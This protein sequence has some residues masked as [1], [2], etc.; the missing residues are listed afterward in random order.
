[1]IARGIVVLFLLLTMGMDGHSQVTVTDDVLELKTG[2]IDI[3]FRKHTTGIVYLNRLSRVGQNGLIQ[4]PDPDLAKWKVSPLWLVE[5][6]GQPDFLGPAQCTFSDWEIRSSATRHRIQIVWDLPVEADMLQ[7][8]ANIDIPRGGEST[9]WTLEIRSRGGSPF[10]VTR[11]RY[12]IVGDMVLSGPTGNIRIAYPNSWG[13]EYFKAENSAVFA[14][15]PSSDCQM[16]FMAYYN[17]RTEE[18]LYFCAL[19]T[20]GY[21]KILSNHEGNPTIPFARAQ[22]AVLPEATASTRWETPYATEVRCYSGNW[23]EAA[24]FYRQWRLSTAGGLRPNSEKAP[25]WLVKNDFWFETGPENDT[26]FDFTN[27]P[28]LNLIQELVDSLGVSTAIH[29]YNWYKYPFDTYYPDY[30]PIRPGFDSFQERMR[31]SGIRLVPYINGRIADKRIIEDDPRFFEAVCRTNVG[32]SPAIASREYAGNE[33]GT[34]C[35]STAFWQDTLVSISRRLIEEFGFDGVYFDQICN[36]TGD[37]CI[38]PGHGHLSDPPTPHPFS[39]GNHWVSGYEAMLKKVHQLREANPDIMFF[40]EDAADAWNDLFSGYLMVNCQ[41][42]DP[43]GTYRLVPLFPAVYSGYAIPIGFQYAQMPPDKWLPTLLSKFGRAFVWGSQLGWIKPEHLKR[44]PTLLE[45]AQGLA[46]ARQQIHDYLN[47]GEMKRT[48]ELNTDLGTIS[49]DEIIKVGKNEY[50]PIRF[51]LP[52]VLTA[53]WELNAD[54]ATV[55]VTNFTESDYR[56]RPLSLTVDLGDTR[57]G[58]GRYRMIENGMDIGQVEVA[59]A[60]MEIPTKIG[61]LDTRTLEFARIR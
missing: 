5:I 44:S 6:L 18:G 30:F 31:G 29:L 55:L 15:F 13:H 46:G 10:T 1:M 49:I 51:E 23:Y 25:D 14:R 7:V 16:P 28:R 59:G 36:N 52:P 58:E 53:F 12:P 11:L 24:K 26:A 34:M 57:L 40:S 61:P 32:G 48:P 43:D 9:I 39:Y 60:T 4:P 47:F 50:R 38:S 22:M 45:Y 42:T 20:A 3:S 2:T 56:N 27:T 33:F 35:P 21:Q 19:D 37:K 8:N 41:S 17:D 54:S